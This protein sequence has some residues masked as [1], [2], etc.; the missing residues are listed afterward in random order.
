[1]SEELKKADRK[2]K[3]KNY[4]LTG[5][6]FTV[7]LVLILAPILYFGW[8]LY[9]SYRDSRTPVFGNRYDGDLNPAI[10]KA[11]L[12]T[13]DQKVG[14]IE[15]IEKHWVDLT[16]ATLRVY[17]DVQDDATSEVVQAKADEIYAK[18]VEDLDPAIYFS[19]HDGMKMYDIEV[20]VYNLAENRDSEGFVYGIENKSSKMEAP[21]FQIMSQPVN[22]EIAQKLRDD[23]VARE[24]KKKAEQ[25]AAQAQQEGGEVE[26]TTEEAEQ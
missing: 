5:I 8:M 10:T 12:E 23:V 18:I 19:Q 15:G 22:A 16:T 21:K 6:F 11:Q 3:T 4:H 13:L 24:E 26:T 25:E 7:F 1:M 2:I 14:T 9:S 20:H 17:A